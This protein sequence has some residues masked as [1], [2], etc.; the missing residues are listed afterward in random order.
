MNLSQAVLWGGTGP[1]TRLGWT[2]GSF[3]SKAIRTPLPFGPQGRHKQRGC[4]P[5]PAHPNPGGPRAPSAAHGRNS[6]TSS[7]LRTP[8][9]WT[10]KGQ[11]NLP[12]RWG[13]SCRNHFT[14]GAAQVMGL[15]STTGPSKQLPPEPGFWPAHPLLLR[16][17]RESLLLDRRCCAVTLVPQENLWLIGQWRPG[18][19]SKQSKQLRHTRGTWL[20]GHRAAVKCSFTSSR[21]RQ[22]QLVPTQT[23]PSAASC[24]SGWTS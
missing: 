16:P 21:A 24:A 14:T 19:S 12:H 17:Q 11:T 4:T 22:F 7:P 8:P 20:A 2:G 18:R 13:P 1:R 15:C 10:Q 6:R 5:R 23:Y 3:R 9:P